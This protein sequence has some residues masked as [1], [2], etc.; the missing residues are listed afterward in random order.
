MFLVARSFLSTPRGAS[1][2]GHAPPPSCHP[3]RE[4]SCSGLSCL[5]GP[6]SWW[7]AGRV[8]LSVPSVTQLAAPCPRSPPG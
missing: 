4:D 6:L 3:Q 8:L 2:R 5:V 7:R 1:A